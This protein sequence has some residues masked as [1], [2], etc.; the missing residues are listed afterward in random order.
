[1]PCFKQS[2]YAGPITIFEHDWAVNQR[3]AIALALTGFIRFTWGEVEE[4]NFED[5]VPGWEKAEK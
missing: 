2:R 5:T 1:M 3:K 4:E